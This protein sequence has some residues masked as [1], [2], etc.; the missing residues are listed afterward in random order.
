MNRL[1][2]RP[3]TSISLL[4]IDA[5]ADGPFTG[6]PAAVC[7]LAEPAS[8]EWMQR[9]AA[10]M[11]LS[12]TAF[13]V[14]RGD[15]SFDL[16]WFMPITE[17]D[18]CGHATLAAA[19][20][21]WEWR[22]IQPG[23]SARFHT[24]GGLLTCRRDGDWIAMDF[25]ASPPTQIEP[26]SGLEKALGAEP[27]WVGVNSLNY[28]IAELADEQTVRSDSPAY[29]RFADWAYLGYCV[30][31]KSEAHGFDFISRFFCPAAKIEDPVTGS[32]HCALAPFWAERLRKV[33][34]TALQAS[35]RSGVVRCRLAG[36]R[37]A[38]IG[39]AVTVLR[40]EL[41]EAASKSKSA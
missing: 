6:N 34:F 4:Q 7:L 31:A 25:P 27:R 17:V 15:G 9:V 40:G 32:A 8:A 11:N 18:L 23:E 36:D 39:R 22:L 38:L 3:M 20:A 5:F 14:A 29:E 35:A 33:D 16:R 26:P 21:V 19:H 12:E 37:V 1:T 2:A 28:L 10:E 30:T 13:L 24:K 41:T